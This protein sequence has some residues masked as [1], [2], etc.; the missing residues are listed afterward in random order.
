MARCLDVFNEQFRPAG[1]EQGLNPAWQ[2][3]AWPWQQPQSGTALPGVPGHGAGTSCIWEI[4]LF[5][6]RKKKASL[7]KDRNKLPDQVIHL[8][9][10]C[11]KMIHVFQFT[12][13]SNL[14]YISPDCS[15]P[16]AAG[17]REH[18][19]HRCAALAAPNA[20]PMELE[21]NCWL[22]DR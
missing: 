14:K 8:R 17:H 10:V 1:P 4:T 3:Q 15:P 2:H 5:T 6:E 22:V 12:P 11:V 7:W 20:C 13:S 19:A 16:R 21:P 18:P 9:S